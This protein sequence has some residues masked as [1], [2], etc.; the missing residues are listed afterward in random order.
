[1]PW[2]DREWHCFAIVDE[3]GTAT[4]GT[5]ERL[6]NAGRRVSG[7]YFPTLSKLLTAPLAALVVSRA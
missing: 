4:E 7:S 2:M 5:G 1:M 6:G 3:V